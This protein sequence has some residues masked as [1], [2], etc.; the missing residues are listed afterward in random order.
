M[1][2]RQPAQGETQMDLKRILRHVPDFPRPGIDFIDITTVLQDPAALKFCL[3]GMG[4]KLKE[5]GDFDLIVGPESRGFIFG[6]PLAYQHGKGFIPIRK[7]GKL[8][9][10]TIRVEY[11][12]EYGTDVLEMHRDAIRPGQRVLIVDDLLATG[13]T[14][15][16]NICLV[17]QLGGVIVGILYFIELTFLNGRSRLKGLPVTSLVTF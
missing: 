5:F 2:S 15:E 11:V 13:G 6:V 7:K 3:D 17:H 16:A 8:P 10:E 12:L 4:E 14:T 1:P 9:A